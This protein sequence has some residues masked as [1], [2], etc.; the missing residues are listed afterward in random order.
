MRPLPTPNCI[1]NVSPL[2]D[3]DNERVGAFAMVSDI[4][5]RKEAEEV[6]KESEKRVQTI[7]NVI[8]T[9]VIIIDPENRTIVDVNP[10]AAQMIGLTDKEIIGQICHQF[11]CPKKMN[12]CPV[13][14]SDQTVENA[15]RM[16]VTGAG[17]EIP[18]LKTVTRIN[19]SGK[20]H[21]LESFINISERKKADQELKDRLDELERFSRLTV[22][23]ELKMIDLKEEVNHLLEQ[24]SR[25]EKYEIVK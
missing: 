23:R 11:I 17:E 6:L 8:N 4:S 13:L 10:V 22:D 12:D 21:L 7:L 3:Q 5:E 20:P 18:I 9:G 2:Y 16:L 1:F 15:E 24:L 25:E 19:L 14:D